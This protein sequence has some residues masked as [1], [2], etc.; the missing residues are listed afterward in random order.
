MRFWALIVS[1]LAVGLVA[2]PVLA[3]SQRGSDECAAGDPDRRIEVCTR[4]IRGRGASAK[5]RALAYSRRGNAYR[6]KGDYERALADYREAI[7]RSPM[8][9][10]AYYNRGKTHSDM[11]EFDR[12]IADYSEVISLD[13][14]DADAYVD[15]GLAYLFSG[16]LAGAEADLRQA[17]ELAPQDAYAVLWLDI[18]ERRKNVPHHLEQAI[19]QLDMSAWPAPVTR[20]FLDQAT[21]AGVLAAANDSDPKTKQ[22]QVCEANF[23][24]G[25][26]ALLRGEREEAA[27]LFRLAASDCPRGSTEWSAASAELRALGRQ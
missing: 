21:P 14:K 18:A 16:S 7:R 10:I 12:A 22:R 5:N 24:G 26:L 3:A 9:T 13:P 27:R 25:E 17:R 19:P 2:N 6:E 20:L 8:D 11:G 23:Y 1:V 4:I 15:R